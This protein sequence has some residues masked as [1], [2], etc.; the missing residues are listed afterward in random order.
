MRCPNCCSEKLVKNREGLV[1]TNCG[2][3]AKKRE[4]LKKEVNEN[5]K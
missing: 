1:C 3:I 5:S 4:D 2:I